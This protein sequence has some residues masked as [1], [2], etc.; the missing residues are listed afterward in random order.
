MGSKFE[1]K[2]EMID[3]ITSPVKEKILKF[4]RLNNIISV[5]VSDNKVN[6]L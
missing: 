3:T 5:K 2:Q 1:E 6:I 4:L